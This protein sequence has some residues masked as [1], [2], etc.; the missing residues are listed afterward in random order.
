MLVK[1]LSC[2][3]K[4]PYCL[5]Q[6]LN[7][8]KNSKLNRN[9]KSIIGFNKEPLIDFIPLALYTLAPDKNW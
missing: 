4:F 1:N 7:R 5:Y 2:K 8:F 9:F 3:S 6:S